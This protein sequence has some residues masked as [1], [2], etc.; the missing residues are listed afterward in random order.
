MQDVLELMK[1]IGPA[2]VQLPQNDRG[3]LCRSL[4]NFMEAEEAKLK[5]EQTDA[6]A[7]QAYANI[8]LPS[9]QPSASHSENLSK[10]TDEHDFTTPAGTH[11]AAGPVPQDTRAL[12]SF[13]CS[14]E[15]TYGYDF[16]RTPNTSANHANDRR[17]SLRP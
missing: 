11:L 6:A 9:Q 1:V 5:R 3:V 14:P 17:T 13:T 4:L 8:S 2:V 12:P 15:L 16:Y 10:L 7:A